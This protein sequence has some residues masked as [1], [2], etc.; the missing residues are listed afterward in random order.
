MKYT[1]MLYF[2]Y[3]YPIKGQ[4]QITLNKPDGYNLM[5]YTPK[6]IYLK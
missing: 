6:L 3:R 2:A 5:G 1:K 4:A